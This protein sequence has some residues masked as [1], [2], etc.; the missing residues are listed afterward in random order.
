[1][2][3]RYYEDQQINKNVKSIFLAGPTPRNNG[4]KSWRPIAIQLLKDLGFDGEVFS[5]ESKTGTFGDLD[6]KEV[7]D[8]ELEHLDRSSIILFWIPRELT[9]MPAFTTNVEFGY[10]LKTG[11]VIYGRP[12]DA[13]KNRYLDYL[14]E[15]EYKQK[16][17]KTL[18]E[19]IIRC[20]DSLKE[21]Q[22]QTF[23]TSD[24]HFG[25]ERTLKFSSRPY[26]N[27]QEMDNDFIRKWNSKISSNDIV[28][29]LGDFGNFD[30]VDKLNGKIVLVLGNYEKKDMTENFNGNF[31]SYK[32]MLI[33]KGF[34]NVIENGI[35][36]DLDSEKV[37]LTHEPLDCKNDMFNLFGHIHEKCMCK[38]F[39]LN[40]GIDCLNFAPFSENEVIF[41][42]NAIQ[43]HYDNNVFC[44]SQDL[45]HKK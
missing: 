7:I 2:I 20:L 18:E 39:G 10:H 4:V 6:Y 8:W 29:H 35:C 26:K 40:V 34:S 17:A 12:D 9:N 43:K 32:K 14:F 13:P 21:K 33:E 37:Y 42:K 38:K 23:Y 5:P 22:P 3:I 27:T 28:Y 36:V 30:I 16:P 1:M 15:K 19:S 44:T 11:K 31:E 25:S 24:T 45:K 41:Y